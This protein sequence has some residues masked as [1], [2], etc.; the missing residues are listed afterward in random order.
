MYYHLHVMATATEGT[1]RRSLVF[2]IPNKSKY[3]KPAPWDKF[4]SI[5]GAARRPFITNARKNPPPKT[6]EACLYAPCFSYHGQKKEK[7]RVDEEGRASLS[8]LRVPLSIPHLSWV[9]TK[10]PSAPSLSPSFL[11]SSNP[12]HWALAATLWP[13]ILP[14][15]H[16]IPPAPLAFVFTTLHWPGFLQA[17]A[18]LTLILPLRFLSK[19][20]TMRIR[21]HHASGEKVNKGPGI[22]KLE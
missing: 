19:V 3:T 12:S 8:L 5:P 16:P 2:Y 15:P 10:P 18:A 4:F 7:L 1:S 21:A 13:S 22:Y 11:S 6:D 14:H 9:R 20:C 17:L